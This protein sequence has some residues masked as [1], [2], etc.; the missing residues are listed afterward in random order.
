MESD[1]AS[2]PKSP[3]TDGSDVGSVV[4][5]NLIFSIKED[6]RPGSDSVGVI[7]KEMDSTSTSASSVRNDIDKNYEDVSNMLK[8]MRMRREQLVERRG[9]AADKPHVEPIDAE[10]EEEEGY[11]E[12]TEA[13]AAA[14]KQPLYERVRFP[15]ATSATPATPVTPP[16]ATPAGNFYHSDSIDSVS[17]MEYK[18]V[19]SRSYRR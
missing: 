5:S 10:E 14:A 11:I 3:E 17:D 15:Q 18:P 9:A 1:A 4:K 19:W 8:R 12:M 13:A 6:R 7:T 2:V 16:A